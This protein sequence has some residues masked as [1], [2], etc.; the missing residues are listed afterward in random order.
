MLLGALVVK[1]S[2]RTLQAGIDR[3]DKSP[4]LAWTQLG[5]Q[6]RSEPVDFHV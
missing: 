5:V 4:I 2:S 1:V 3:T 6:C